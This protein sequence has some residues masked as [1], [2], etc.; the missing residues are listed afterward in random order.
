[1]RTDLHA[2]RL[3]G[4]EIIVQLSRDRASLSVLLPLS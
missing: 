4:R 2:R 3:D 1:M